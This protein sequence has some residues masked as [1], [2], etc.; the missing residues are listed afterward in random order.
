MTNSLDHSQ[1]EEE[2]PQRPPR[3]LAEWVSFCLASTVLAAVGGLVIYSWTTQKD[4]PPIL[5]VE[6]SSEIRFHQEAF[7]ISFAVKNEGGETVESVQIIA[8]LRVQ[9]EV[10]ETGEQ[11]IDFLSRNEEEE[12][13]FIF[14]R[15]PR[16]G[17]LTIRV[18]SYK[19]P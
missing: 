15:D 13:A 8:E 7:Y 2:S 16:K 9:G 19:L 10:V 17:E 1:P 12:G 11:S 6:Q 4:L 18:A 5:K 14:Q 3:S